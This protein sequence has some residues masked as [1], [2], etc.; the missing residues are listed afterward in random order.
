MDLASIQTPAFIYLSTVE[1]EVPV[2]PFM[3][4]VAVTLICNIFYSSET[5]TTS[6]AKNSIKST[7]IWL[8][9]V[10]LIT[11]YT[12]VAVVQVLYK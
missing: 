12:I 5:P 4:S 6:H 3:R 1:W 11:T 8:V 9:S 2:I 7:V 10:D